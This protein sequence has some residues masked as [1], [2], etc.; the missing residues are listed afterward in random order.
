VLEGKQGLLKS[1][2]VRVLVPDPTWFA[3]TRIDLGSKDAYLALSG[4]WLYEVA[5]LE[6]FSG[7]GA[8]RLKSFV[9]S[10][11]DTYRVPYGRS[12]QAYPRQTV[13][14]ATT[15][16]SDYVSDW[17]GER[18]K[19]PVPVERVDLDAIARDRDCLWAEAR[20]A[21]EAGER[22]HLEGEA[23]AAM[24]ELAMERH[25]ADPL[26]EVA[27]DAIGF[28]SSTPKPPRAPTG[29]SATSRRRSSTPRWMG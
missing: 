8:N 10:A 29:T 3:D 6:S 11:T 23:A 5:E 2:A 25:V 15:N 9:S 22:W 1:S 26:E 12:T 28:T 20:A 7:W 18:R 21:F 13:F 16:D 17:T 24:S 27:W 19:W 14:V 4:V